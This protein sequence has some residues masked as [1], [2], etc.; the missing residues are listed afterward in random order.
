LV[1]KQESDEEEESIHGIGS[2]SRI[3]TVKQ[4][5]EKGDVRE[6][7]NVSSSIFRETT[8]QMARESSTFAARISE[9]IETSMAFSKQYLIRKWVLMI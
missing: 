8:A 3:K 5:G 1:D 2:I 9:Q 7:W 6:E 4:F